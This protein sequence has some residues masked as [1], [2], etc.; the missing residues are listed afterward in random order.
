MSRRTTIARSAT[1]L[2]GACALAACGASPKPEPVAVQAPQPDPELRDRIDG[3]AALAV[4][5]E[6]LN[7]ALLRR[8]YV[9]RGFEPVWTTRPAQAASLVNAVLRAGDQGL[10]PALFHADLLRRRATLPPLDRELVLSDAVL[11]Y[12]DALARGAVPLGQRSDDEVL[13]P[14]PVDVAAVLDTA[15]GSADPA[16]VIE[17]LAPATPT[18]RALRRA[19]RQYR[20]GAPAGGTAATELLRTI[21]VP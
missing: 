4:A 14:G 16:A 2:A 10:D 15:A 21:E 20:A 19:L 9:R 8:F 5:G 3:A 17:A 18:Y 6:P 11:T 7:V 12:A 1:A 13:T